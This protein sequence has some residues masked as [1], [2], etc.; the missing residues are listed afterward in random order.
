MLEMEDQRMGLK[1]I[2]PNYMIL[3]TATKLFRI[4]IL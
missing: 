1:I 3:K 2:I 4:E